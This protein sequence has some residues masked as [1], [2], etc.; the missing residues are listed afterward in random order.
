MI[1]LLHPRFTRWRTYWALQQLHLGNE[2]SSSQLMHQLNHSTGHRQNVSTN[3]HCKSSKQIVE[4]T[5]SGQGIMIKKWLRDCS[6]NF[7]K[8]NQVLLA[9]EVKTWINSRSKTLLTQRYS[10]NFFA[11][12]P[13]MVIIS[14]YGHVVM[15]ES[16]VLPSHHQNCWTFLDS[17]RKRR[18]ISELSAIWF[19]AKKIRIC[20]KA[21]SALNCRH[22]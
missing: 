22:L 14:F 10:M 17:S 5:Y 11:F 1:S 12:R 7:S 9:L 2:F 15:T 21:D 6:E 20:G 8:P 16:A 4:E 19:V 13:L 18:L 3:Q